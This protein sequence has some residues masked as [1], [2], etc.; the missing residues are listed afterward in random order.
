MKQELCA[1]LGDF[2]GVHIGHIAVIKTAVENCGN[3]IPVVYTF[4]QNC[5]K[6]KLITTNSEKEKFI[7]S[8]GIKRVIFDDFETIRNYSP[9]QFVQDILLKKYNIKTIVC[10]TDF[11]FGK[12]A[13]GN[14]DTLKDLCHRF[15]LRL[16]LVDSVEVNGHKISSST[17]RSAIQKGDMLTTSQLLGRTFSITGT[18]RQGKGLGHLKNTPTVNLN[19]DSQAIIPAYGVYITRTIVDNIVYNSIS[20]IGVRPSVENTNQ[21]NIETNIFD[22]NN[23]IYGKTVTI[24]FFKMLRPEIKFDNIDDLFKQI[25]HDISQAKKYFSEENSEKIY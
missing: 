14:V 20:N 17:I 19:L 10:G 7:L 2:D 13:E 5:K 1:A 24:E 9:L 12:N 11:R 22:F 8:L 18:V 23:D 6:A 25:N 15:N 3:H 16:I 21:A 4:S